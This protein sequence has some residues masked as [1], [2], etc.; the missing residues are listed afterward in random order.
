VKV[1]RN[2][3]DKLVAICDENLLGKELEVAG[4]R[5]VVSGE[6]YGGERVPV[7]RIW[8]YLEGATMVNAIGDCV[9]QELS[10]R[11]PAAS[12]AAVRVGGV[13]HVQLLLR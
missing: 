7:S 11:I 9:V 10:K 13:L 3:S 4:Y 8:E 1:H 12:L 5:I 2:G 6:F